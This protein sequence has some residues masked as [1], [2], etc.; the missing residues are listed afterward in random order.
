VRPSWRPELL[1]ILAGTL[2][3]TGAQGPAS[4]V[5]YGVQVVRAGPNGRRVVGSGA[6]S[7]PGETALRL[8]LRG[9]SLE[10]EGLFSVDP[11][12]DS[13]V[14]LIGDFTTRRRVGR[15][16]RGLPLWEQD[17]YRR[18]QPMIWGDT[19]RVYPSGVPRAGAAESLWV[20]VAV[21]RRAAG[22]ETRPTSTVT[23]GDAELEIALEAVARPRRA[24]VWLTLVRG[25]TSSPPRR[26]DL[27]IEGGTRIMDLPVGLAQRRTLEFTMARPEPSRVERERTLATDAD[28]VCLRV[29]EP[30]GA[31]PLQT[32]CGRLNNV[33][34]RLPLA[35]GDTLVAT[36]A[37][38][39][40]R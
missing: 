33:A 8:A 14:T 23:A 36:F 5:E 20:E 38:P 34:Y 7:G 22:A 31:Q 25:D 28:V 1:L 29:G 19:A 30:G 3:V 9:D 39:A 21:A 32:V 12:I 18:T 35:G 6:V 15:S 26:M 17:S 2:G 27:A 24:V 40:A 11:G 10:I 4:R 13:A 37:W 16:G